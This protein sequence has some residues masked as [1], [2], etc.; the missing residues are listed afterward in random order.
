MRLLQ[1]NNVGE[2]SLTRDL[3]SNDTIPPEAILSHT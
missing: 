3:T 2:F 1:C